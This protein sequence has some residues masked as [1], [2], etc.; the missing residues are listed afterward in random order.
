VSLTP[1]QIADIETKAAAVGLDLRQ[2]ARKTITTPLEDI[3]FMG[4]GE[5]HEGELYRLG[6]GFRS[7]QER[8]HDL[9][10]EATVTV[11]LP[12]DPRPGQQVADK[13]GDAWT[14]IDIGDEEPRL[15]NTASLIRLWTRDELDAAYGPLRP[16]E[17]VALPA[18]EDQ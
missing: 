9:V 3:D 16:V 13:D 8:I 12:G 5:Q 11:R 10:S 17:T 15:I 18:E 1:E 7:A 4:V 14:Y 6:A 2:M